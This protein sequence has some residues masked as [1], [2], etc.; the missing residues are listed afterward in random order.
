MAACQASSRTARMYGGRWACCAQR[1]EWADRVAFFKFIWGSGAGGRDPAWGKVGA[2]VS[3]PRTCY[4]TICLGGLRPLAAARKLHT[5]RGRNNSP[6]QLSRP[7]EA[8]D[9]AHSAPRPQPGPLPTAAPGDT[10]RARAVDIGIALK[11]CSVTRLSAAQSH[12][13]TAER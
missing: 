9:P 4:P 11:Q 3:P 6:I 2:R 8:P 7:R 1:P 13:T 10:G 5:Q 12:S